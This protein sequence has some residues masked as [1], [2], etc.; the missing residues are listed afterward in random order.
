MH[1]LFRYYSVVVPPVL[2]SEIQADYSKRKIGPKQFSFLVKKFENHSFEAIVD[3]RRL[4]RGNL[5]GDDVPMDGRPVV[6]GHQL[7]EGLHATAVFT[8]SERSKTIERWLTG[9]ISPAEIAA[10]QEWRS[11]SKSIDLEKFRHTFKDMP[12][13]KLSTPKQALQFVDACLINGKQERLL[14]TMASDARLTGPEMADLRERWTKA[15]KP[16]MASFAPYAT[17]CTRAASVFTIALMNGIVTTRPTNYIDLQYLYYLPFCQAFS[18]GDKLHADLGSLFLRADQIAI[19]S[20]LLKYD[21]EALQTFWSGLS[22]AQRHIWIQRFGFWPPT[23][24]HSFTYQAWKRFAVP[25]K[26]SGN[27]LSKLPPDVRRK[28]QEEFQAAVTQW[29]ARGNTSEPEMVI[30]SINLPGSGI[31]GIVMDKRNAWRYQ[32]R[33]SEEL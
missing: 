29:K 13:P 21:L 3:Q 12:L 20:A 8:K 11:G 27:A 30:K 17:Y 1:A 19:N 2:V 5:L 32:S 7:S 25:K 23:A 15:G 16:P 28:V 24:S 33:P 10:S 9:C 4:M 31:S 18:S 22:F 6:P 26:Y 14:E